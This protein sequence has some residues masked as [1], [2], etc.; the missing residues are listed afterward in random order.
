MDTF[1]AI[2]L[3]IVQGLTEFLPVSSSGHLVLGHAI[4][5]GVGESALSFDIMLH[6]ATALAIIVYFHKD[7]QQMALAFLRVIGRLPADVR[8]VT[9]LQALLI[10][11]IPGAV[12]GFFF[13]DIITS[14]FRTPLAVAGVLVLGSIFFL[15]AERRYARHK[16]MKK[17]TVYRGF[18]IG[19][20]QTLALM[21][22]FSRSGAT[23]ATG[24]LTGLSRIDAT[25]FS[26]LLALPI[27]LGAAARKLLDM[28]QEGMGDI[29]VGT[30]LM[31]GISAFVVAL[32]AIHFMLSYMRRHT[33][34]SFVWYRLTLAALIV[35]F[36]SIQ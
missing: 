30:V 32:F 28:A 24:M 3:G 8:D 19:V 27:I 21:P 23:I 34:H 16:K 9:L 26:F 29:A 4:F 36:V 10:G 17:L 15:Y 13:E 2:L 12:I 22:G 5:G 20:F 33:L 1:S 7:L 6:F 31:G 35:V 11:T 18:V 25:R 14:Y